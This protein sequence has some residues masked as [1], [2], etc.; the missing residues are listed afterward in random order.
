[1][2]PRPPCETVPAEDKKSKRKTDNRHT[3]TRTRIISCQT[4]EAKLNYLE[5][6]QHVIHMY[7]NMYINK[8]A[9]TERERA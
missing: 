7:I 8:T 9:E 1:M 4:S 3:N 2:S 5:Y 6:H